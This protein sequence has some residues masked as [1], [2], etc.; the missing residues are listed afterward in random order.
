MELD[1]QTLKDL[2]EMNVLI[3]D[4]NPAN[5]DILWKTLEQ[6]GYQIAVASDGESAL[7]TTANVAPDLIL[8]D[9]MMPGIDGYETCRRLKAD[10]ATRDI[11]VI[12]ITA[13]TETEDLVKGFDL[14]GVDYITKPIR[15]EEVCVRVQTHLWL[16]KLR[17]DLA[18]KNQEL[19]N[20]NARLAELD[21]IKTGLLNNLNDKTRSLEQL[22]EAHHSLTN[23]LEMKNMHLEESEREAVKKNQE[24]ETVNKELTRLND[25]LV[26]HG[27]SL[28]KDD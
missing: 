3:V 9:I 1:E 5:L 24:L 19:E 6:E 4:D 18:K 21:K 27:I 13:K 25:L 10:P 17:T 26:Q 12:F 14:G 22:N 28:E 15:Q 23:D 11:P 7:E 16:R 2:K 8:L 20:A